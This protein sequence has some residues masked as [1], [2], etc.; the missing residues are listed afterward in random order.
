MTFLN[1]VMKEVRMPTIVFL[2]TL[3]AQNGLDILYSQ[4]K[5]EIKKISSTDSEEKNFSI[6]KKADAYQV[7]AARD[8]VPKYLQVDKDFLK[9]VPNLLIVSSSGAGYD[10]VDVGACTEAGVLVVNQTGG[11]AEGVAEHAVAMILN[12]F[13][14]I[15]E[16]DHALRRGWNESRVNLMGKDLLNKTVGIIGLG[17]TG[18]RVAEI[19]KLAFNCEI[20]AYDP[21]LADELFEKKH[22]KKSSL[23][24]LLELSDVVTVHVP[25]N[26]ETR[27]MINMDFFRKMKR[28]G[29]FVTTARGSIHNEK[30]L[31]E[32][33][34]SGHLAGAGLDVWDYEPPP[35]K[36]KL[37]ELENV[38]ASPHTAGVTR[39]SRNKMSEFVATQLLD[40]FDGKEPARPVNPEIINIYKEKFKKII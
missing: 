11:N 15:G 18:G 14:R 22:A 23:D 21:Y 16:A 20:L 36:H 1:Y 32:I 4:S 3:P 19:C 7:G 25:L 17:N 6:L 30:D 10:T 9:K 26:N 12:L 13:K 37:L 29:Y 39:D 33:L 28:G 5:V 8:E 38:I 35:A 27:N 40:L 24:N 31:Y 34:I 2:D